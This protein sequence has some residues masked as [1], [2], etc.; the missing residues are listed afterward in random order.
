MFLLL[1]LNKQMLAGL[2]LNILILILQP[3]ID[4]KGDYLETFYLSKALVKHS[5]ISHQSYSQICILDE[6]LI[7]SGFF[8]REIGLY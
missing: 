7:A 6:P 3:I 4:T 8:Y 2:V 5:D 1:T